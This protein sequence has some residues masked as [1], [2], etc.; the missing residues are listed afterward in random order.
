[1][2]RTRRGRR[3]IVERPPK[4]QR[5]SEMRP[6]FLSRDTLDEPPP[7]PLGPAHVRR[8]TTDSG[9]AAETWISERLVASNEGRENNLEV[10]R[11]SRAVRNNFKEGD[12]A[13]VSLNYDGVVWRSLGTI[14]CLTNDDCV[15]VFLCYPEI[16][17][18][19]PWTMASDALSRLSENERT[20]ITGSCLDAERQIFS[21]DLALNDYHWPM[22]AVNDESSDAMTDALAAA[23]IEDE[24]RVA[25]VK[26]TR[27]V[28][29][30]HLF[31][32]EAMDLKLGFAIARCGDPKER[33]A[34]LRV[35]Y[36]TK[37]AEEAAVVLGELKEALQRVNSDVTE[38][39]PPGDV[40]AARLLR[41]TACPTATP[42]HAWTVQHAWMAAVT[43]AVQAS[44][45]S[46]L[47]DGIR[48]VLRTTGEVLRI[49]FRRHVVSRRGVVAHVVPGLRGAD[50]NA[51]EIL[52]TPVLQPL[53]DF[54]VASAVPTSQRHHELRE[55]PR[56]I[57]QALTFL[58]SI[59]RR[60]AEPRLREGFI[61]ELTDAVSSGLSNT[62][63]DTIARDYRVI[64][65]AAADQAQRRVSV[66]GLPVDEEL[67]FDDDAVA[68][69]LTQ[70]NFGRVRQ[71]NWSRIEC[72]TSWL[73]DL[74]LRPE[75]AAI[76]ERYGTEWVDMEETDI[77]DAGALQP[78]ECDHAIHRSSVVEFFLA[79]DIVP[80]VKLD[81]VDAL[82][83]ANLN[84]ERRL[85][86]D[87]RDVT[88]RRDAV[89]FKSLGV[90]EAELR[91][92]SSTSGG[93]SVDAAEEKTTS[94][95]DPG[96]DPMAF[97][98]KPH[99]MS[100][101]SRES[102]WL[103]KEMQMNFAETK[104][105]LESIV[106]LFE[107]AEDTDG[108]DLT[109]SLRRCLKPLF[110]A[111]DGA[112][113]MAM[114]KYQ[115]IVFKQ[116][117]GR[118]EAGE[119]PFPSDDES[120]SLDAGFESEDDE[121]QGDEFPAEERLADEAPRPAIRNNVSVV[122]AKESVA[123]MSTTLLMGVW[124]ML[125]SAMRNVMKLAPWLTPLAAIFRKTE[126]RVNFLFRCGKLREAMGE[127]ESIFVGYY[128]FAL[129]E[130]RRDG[131]V[132]HNTYNE[133]D[134]WLDNG[135]FAACPALRALHE[136]HELMA[137]A[138]NIHLAMRAG[139]LPYLL[140]AL[141]HLRVLC[142]VT[143]GDKYTRGLTHFLVMLRTMPETELAMTCRLMFVDMGISGYMGADEF[144]ERV[145]WQFNEDLPQFSSTNNFVARLQHLSLNMASSRSAYALGANRTSRKP[146]FGVIEVD[147]V[148]VALVQDYF[149]QHF[150]VEKPDVGLVWVDPAGNERLLEESSGDVDERADED[151][152]GSPSLYLIDGRESTAVALDPMRAGRGIA[153]IDDEANFLPTADD[154]HR[155]VTKIS[156]PR[157]PRPHFTAAEQ[158]KLDDVATKQRESRTPTDIDA[159]FHRYKQGMLLTIQAY[160]AAAASADP[161]EPPAVITAELESNY[162][163]LVPTE[164]ANRSAQANAISRWRTLASDWCAL[165]DGQQRDSG[166]DDVS[167]R[168]V[169]TLMK[170]ERSSAQLRAVGRGL[171]GDVSYSAPVPSSLDRGAV[172]VAG[173]RAAEQLLGSL[174]RGA[175]RKT[176]TPES[177]F[178]EL[179]RNIKPYGI[180]DVKW[181]QNFKFEAAGLLGRATAG[182]RLHMEDPDFSSRRLKMM[183]DFR[184]RQR[185]SDPEV[186]V[187]ERRFYKE[188][189]AQRNTSRWNATTLA[190]PP[191]AAGTLFE[192]LKRRAHD[193]REATATAVL[194]AGSR[195]AGSAAPRTS[196]S[197]PR[198]GGGQRRA[199]PDLRA[200]E[201]ELVAQFFDEHDGLWQRKRL[202]QPYRRDLIARL[203]NELGSSDYYVTT[204]LTDAQQKY[205]NKKLTEL[206]NEVRAI[207]PRRSNRI[208]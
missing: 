55:C 74:K 156:R 82:A 84:R 53:L 70:D 8:R 50:A 143:G 48:D 88:V 134:A 32:Q 190:P 24:A 117:L 142:A 171:L 200:K 51:E 60:V 185:T 162:R 4:S 131:S 7:R 151:V 43:Q 18:P 47:M 174:Q 35:R 104:G 173:R 188:R 130:W 202:D 25:R 69:Q 158:R 77:E 89:L 169:V 111:G 6:S 132:D 180:E 19:L 54:L 137:I 179:Q 129:E 57:R 186:L 199:N 17:V 5:L 91:R 44:R 75:E 127:V 136:L 125:L 116:L 45:R 101:W 3:E 205:R 86:I 189:A 123:L 182:L 13:W 23:I 64:Y 52:S 108:L 203:M 157:L 145:H 96:P 62:N 181:S 68:H 170:N 115:K 139:H 121:D 106:L 2:R 176:E 201:I 194:G 135:P 107:A 183:A 138:R 119:F 40:E 11:K 65:S 95:V 155:A 61:Q 99:P 1:M 110:Y 73:R 72:T 85:K 178:E 56:P 165:V 144:T 10:R 133:F 140:V 76:Y 58:T 161:E 92:R 41:E 90:E 20:R 26:R 198:R 168:D 36:A 93:E 30:I 66:A 80:D 100:V 153:R 147:R 87:A 148:I 28:K 167:R 102:L 29:R 79:V 192:W 63:Q 159:A 184:H 193:V 42:Q 94:D 109:E 9:D 164:S 177:A 34:A 120:V 191:A 12:Y 83:A 21:D 128:K 114:Q 105:V 124:H 163:H 27:A 197:G 208:P 172:A 49:G 59:L 81:E 22:H 126:G 118:A 38:L 78:T 187:Q 175:I 37:K 33:T 149:R 204:D 16:T 71:M 46:A 206:L 113:I 97:D 103:R 196:S 141:R 150:F 39:H 98:H 160:A 207:G 152:S 15:D 122:S 112:P 14:K 166:G 31:L 195:A 67:S 146:P 154:P